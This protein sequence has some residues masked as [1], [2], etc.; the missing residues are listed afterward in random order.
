M[1][2]MQSFLEKSN[3]FVNNRPGRKWMNLF[4]K[5][6]TEIS[7]RNTKILSKARASVTEKDIRKWFD[8]KQYLTE[9]DAYDILENLSRVYNI[10]IDETRMSS[11]PK[12]DK[13]LGEKREKI[14]IY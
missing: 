1:C 3:L 4:L 10:H 7:V 13:I 2:K 9:K 11:C 5:R 6:H 8:L 14:N 12:I